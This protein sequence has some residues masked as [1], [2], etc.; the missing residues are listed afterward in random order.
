MIFLTNPGG[1]VA[2]KAQPRYTSGPKKGQF[3]KAPKRRASAKPR[4]AQRTKSNPHRRKTVARKT[5][6]RHKSGPK[7]GQFMKRGGGGGRRR[8]TDSRRSAPARRARRNP[9]RSKGLI[10]DLTDGAIGAAQVLAGKAVVRM[11]ADMLPANLRAGP[12]I[13][14]AVQVAL[15]ILVGT[16]A[17]NF[18]SKQTAHMLLVGGFTGPVEELIVMAN[19]PFLSPALSAYPQ[20]RAYPQEL[21]AAGGLGLQAYPEGAESVDVQGYSQGGY[22]F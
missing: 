17:E 3:K 11:G 13:G 18:V 8:K 1:D 14:P 5:P 6:P 12:M 21:L 19:V 16:L 10:S 22:A 4:A 15:A 20:L 7:K 2:R 9:P